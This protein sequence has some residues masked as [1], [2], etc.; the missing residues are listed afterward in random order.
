VNEAILFD[1]PVLPNVPFDMDFGGGGLPFIEGGT[2]QIQSSVGSALNIIAHGLK[3]DVHGG[4]EFKQ[5]GQEL[6]SVLTP[7]RANLVGD[8]GVDHAA[9]KSIIVCNTTSSKVLYSI[10][11]DNGITY[12]DAQTLYKDIPINP[13]ST[14]VLVQPAHGVLLND[15][16]GSIAVQAS[17]VDS[18]NFILLGRELRG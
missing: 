5:L 9:V 14:R 10:Y 1:T 15:E 17:I 2:L 16:A 3:Y 4:M 7:V 6:P 18:L 13:N 12:G 11:T 8:Q